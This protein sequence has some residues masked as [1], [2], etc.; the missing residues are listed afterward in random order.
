MVVPARRVKT[1]YMKRFKE[2]KWESCGACYLELLRY[3]LSRRLLEQ[4]HRPWLWDGWEQ[5][6]GSGGGSTAGSPSPPGA[7]SP[8]AAQEE[9]AAA[10]AAPAPSEA[11]R[12]SPEKERE[13]QEK[14]QREEQEKTVEHPSVKEADKTS[15][16]G[17]RPSRSALSSRNDRRSAKSPQK[18]D[19][20]KDN[21]HPFALY[22]WGERQTDTG[23]Q[24]THNVCASASANE[25]YLQNW[26]LEM[27]FCILTLMKTRE[28]QQAVSTRHPTAGRFT[29]LLYEQ[30]TGDKWRKGSFP[31]GE[32]DQQKQR[33]LGE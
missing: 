20:P 14:Q 18:T 6:S 4:A 27:Y 33:K 17:Q 12:T 3:R 8:A 31:R 15:R 32:Y 10:A 26:L 29:N 11:G 2:P 5:D 13:D 9:E 19:A 23:S 21:K 25:R 24:K 22:G 30:R 1:E 28:E 16:T 7:G